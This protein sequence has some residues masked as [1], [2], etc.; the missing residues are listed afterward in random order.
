MELYD[1]R[2]ISNKVPCETLRFI[3]VNISLEN[4]ES[5]DELPRPYRGHAC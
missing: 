1:L 4:Q 5:T 2:Y 3:Q